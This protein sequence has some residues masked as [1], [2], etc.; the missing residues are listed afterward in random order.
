VILVPPVFVSESA[1]IEKSVLGPYVSV[2]DGARVSD[3]V[4]RDSIIG[5]GARVD[6]CFLE[7]SLVGANA[8]V[9]AGPRKLNVGDSSEVSLY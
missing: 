4:I 7:R 8:V 2:G 6:G 5:E 9:E 1:V 3:A